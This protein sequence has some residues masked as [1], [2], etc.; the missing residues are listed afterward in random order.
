MAHPYRGDVYKS[1]TAKMT[2]V[3]NPYDAAVV[4]PCAPEWNEY[5]AS[6]PA[7]GDKYGNLGPQAPAADAGENTR[8]INRDPKTYRG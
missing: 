6:K 3:G 5:G 7:I 8:T 2:K 4:S 1:Q